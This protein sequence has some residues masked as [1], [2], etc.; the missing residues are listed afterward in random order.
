MYYH[1]KRFV[2][3][4]TPTCFQCRQCSSKQTKIYRSK[5]SKLIWIARDLEYKNFLFWFSCLWGRFEIKVKRRKKGS[6]LI[7][8]TTMAT[9]RSRYRGSSN[10]NFDV[11]CSYSNSYKEVHV[12][13]S[14]SNCYKK[15]WLTQNQMFSISIPIHNLSSPI[16]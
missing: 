15:G 8:R 10:T 9:T 4:V 14:E 12:G 16:T 3:F 11:G 1:E 7:Q 6:N 13:Q 5:G 2:V